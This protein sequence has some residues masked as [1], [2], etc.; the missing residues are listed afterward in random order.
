MLGP[1]FVAAVAYVD[2][3]N[4]GANLSAGAQYGY[5]LTWVL[6]VASAIAAILQYQSAKLGLVTGRSLTSLVHERLTTRTR[7]PGWGRAYG[8]QAFLI[9]IATD[10]AEVVGGALALNLLFGTPLWLAG[11]IVGVVSVLLLRALRM[12]G[13]HAFELAVAAVLGLVAAGFW[14]ALAFAPPSPG[15]L[16][17]GLVPQVPDTQAWPMIAAMLGATVM[18]HAI[19][20]HSTLAIDRYRPHGP[21]THPLR[22]LLSAQKWDVGVSL[23]VAGSVNIAML[24]LA[25]E[26]LPGT[27]G[28]AVEAAHRIFMIELGPAAATIFALGLLA[29]GVGSTV[30]GTHAGSQVLKD[31]LP[32]TPSPAARRLLTLAPAV[33]VLLAGVPPTTI[34]VASQTVLSFGIAAAVIPLALFT[35][36][37]SIMGDHADGRAMTLVSGLIALLVVALNIMTLVSVFA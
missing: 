36:D 14:G 24:L 30:V 3:G 11:I 16:A 17:A 6:V 34:L 20:L 27:V 26:T 7:S 8:L 12:K 33:L 21:L 19:Y 13:E 1:A 35:R 5:A 10:L 29:S 22:P 18:P 37:R 9:A 31:L 4:V 25:A 15:K 32:K 23:L 2:P 28:E